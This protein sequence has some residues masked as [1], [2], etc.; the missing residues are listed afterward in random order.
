[1]K[2]L[3]LFLALLALN[4]SYIWAF[5]FTFTYNEQTL[6][7]NIVNGEAQVTYP[8][9]T[10]SNPWGG[11]TRPRGSLVIPATVSNNNTA[12]PVTSIDERAFSSC[13]S[14]TSVTIPNSVTSIGEYAFYD[15]SNLSN[16]DLGDSVTSIG[17]F[18]FGRCV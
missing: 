17:Q 18:A 4:F 8:S 1:M 2:K 6:Y 15:C 14:L 10:T 12:Y 16:L 7:Y 3:L 11:Y 9:N 5:N 13:S